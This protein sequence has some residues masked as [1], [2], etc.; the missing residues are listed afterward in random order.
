[1]P[2]WRRTGLLACFTLVA[3]TALTTTG[4]F[5]SQQ[6][7]SI[8][9]GDVSK[10][11]ENLAAITAP[12]KGSFLVLGDWGYDH[13]IHGNAIPACQKKIADLMLTTM[14]E[15]G[16]VKF[17]V[18]VG[19][20]F[21]PRGVTS[22]TD[23]Q[24]DAKWRRVYAPELRAVPWYSVYGNHDYQ[25]DPCACATD[26][27]HCA[28]VQTNTSDRNFF[29]MPGYN[30]FVEHPELDLEVVA[31]DLNDYMWGW[32]KQAPEYSKCA[33]DCTA[34]PCQKGCEYSL[35]ARAE[36]A[37]KLLKERMA[38]STA[39]N[40]IVFSHY[41]TDYLWSNPGLLASLSDASKHH[42]EYF[43]GHRHNVD[44][45]STISI[46]P[47]NNWLVGGG[48]GW[49]CDVLK[50]I[51]QQQGFVVGEIDALGQI[52]TRP[53]LIDNSACCVKPHPAPAPRPGPS[54]GPPRCISKA[55]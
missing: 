48:G 44:Q 25:S 35:R 15:L 40:L 21:Y 10:A 3:C 32:F 34:S 33:W 12:R 46:A 16:D 26:A 37:E 11:T 50:G 7:F 22:K 13:Q 49:S 9:A 27:L 39:K 24:W 28:Q 6:S 29:Y 51:P 5:A 55:R 41:P 43:G 31:M 23:W 18:N 20:S 14:R 42:I 17:V 53:V 38:M 45:N 47:N 2:L 36:E 4:R 1:M 19:D 30:F 8:S 54:P 52:T